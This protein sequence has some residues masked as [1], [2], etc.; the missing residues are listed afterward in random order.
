MGKEEQLLSMSIADSIRQANSYVSKASYIVEGFRSI[1]DVERDN[2]E[3]D[4]IDEMLRWYIE[5]IYRDVATL[6]ERMSVPLTAQRIIAELDK[7]KTG[8]LSDIEPTPYDVTQTSLHLDRIRGYFNSLAVMTQGTEVTGLDV[9]QNILEN[10]PAIIKLTNTDPKKEADVQREVYKVLQIAFPDAM[11]ELPIGQLMK[12]YKPDLGVRSLMAV[13]EYKY[14]ATENEVRRAL[15]GIYTDMKGYSGHYEWRTFFAV[16]YTIDTV[17]NPE[18][19]K[20]E[21]QGMSADANWT[22]IVVVGTGAQ[23]AATLGSKKN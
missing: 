6:A 12:T 21:F 11:R 4:E 20:A 1:D 16:I 5:K 23:R 19:L 10:T 18:R 15:D 14:A 2:P 7:I 22:P 17:V 8:D 3:M 13:A 9:F